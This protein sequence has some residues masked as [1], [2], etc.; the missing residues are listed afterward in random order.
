MSDKDL[1]KLIENLHKEIRNTKRAN[2]KDHAS[3]VQLESEIHNLL[4]RMDENGGKIHPNS[5]KRLRDVLDRFET[6]HPLLTILV[7][8]VL[9]A[10][11]NAGI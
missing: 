6:S 5:I 11:S 9:D 8:Q 10:L 3:L 1:R 4:A 2:E 7:S